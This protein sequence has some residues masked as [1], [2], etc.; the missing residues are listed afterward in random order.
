MVLKFVENPEVKGA[1]VASLRESVGWDSRRVQ[2]E[3]IIGS[4][5]I[6]AACFDGDLLVGHVDVISDG[7]DDALV[8]SLIVRP[9]YQGRGIGRELLRIIINRLREK[10]IKTISVLFE[11]ELANFYHRAGFRVVG[12]GI[13]DT[14]EEGFDCR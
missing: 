11:H 3:K 8:R 7:I 6:A 13:I 9:T 12:G 14:E 2:M 4:S 5:F 1:E 10:K